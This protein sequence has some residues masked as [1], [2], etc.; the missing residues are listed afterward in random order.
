MSF[1]KKLF[2]LGGGAQEADA[3][4]QATESYKGFEIAAHPVSEG[5]QHRLAGTITQQAEDGSV[6]THNLIRA[7]LFPNRDEAVSFTL[8]KAKQVIDE[9]GD[10][11]FG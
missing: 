3:G 11:L 9:Q 2:G 8:R 1:F 5:G 4:S 10:K 7:D 6:H